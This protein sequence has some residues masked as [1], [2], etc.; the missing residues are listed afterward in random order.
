VELLALFARHGKLE[1]GLFFEN[2]FSLTPT[3]HWLGSEG[4]QPRKSLVG[5]RFLRMKVYGQT[6]VISQK[7]WK[8]GSV[9]PPLE[10][11]SA[12]IDCAIIATCL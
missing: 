11:F 4:E 3:R 7:T 5:L 2:S 6:L 8:S 1:S 10:A 12:A 9:W